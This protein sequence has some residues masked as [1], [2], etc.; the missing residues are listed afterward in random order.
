MAFDL[1]TGSQKG[2]VPFPAPASVCNDITIARD[3][4]AYVSDT[5]NGRILK[6]ARGAK[7]LEVFA[8]DERLKGIDG[9]VLSGDGV[10]YVNIVTRG[11]LLRVDRKP[12]GSVGEITQLTTSAPLG[13]PD[14]FR[15]IPSGRF[16]SPRAAPGASMR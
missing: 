15:L 10:L 1:K 7:S 2:V 9:L 14:G 6:L 12:D 11:L 13:A 16:C 3:G 5:P 4:T 8:Q